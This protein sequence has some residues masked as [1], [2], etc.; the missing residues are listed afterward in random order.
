MGY[1]RAPLRAL[2]M[3]ERTA[4]ALLQRQAEAFGD[5]VFVDA[6]GAGPRTY[7]EVRDAVART[8][9]TL[10][11]A[12]VRTGDRVALLSSNRSELIDLVLGCAWMGAVAVPLN[13]ALRAGQLQHVLTN[14]APSVLVVEPQLVESLALV[15]RPDGLDHL[16]VLGQAAVGGPAGFEFEPMP[17]PGDFSEPAAVSPGQTMLILYTSGTTG[18]AKGVCCPQAQFYWWGVINSE[19]LGIDAST[20]LHTTLPLFHTNALNSLFQALVAGATYVSAPRFSASRY[21]QSVTER[22]ADVVYLLGAMIPM[23]LA[24]QPGEF[25]R[26]HRVRL[27]LAPA[28]PPA[29]YSAFADRFGVPLKD[30]YGS[31]ETNHVLGAPGDPTR[32]GYLGR[33]VAEFDVAVVDEHDQVVPDGAAGEMVVRNREPFSMAT[34]YHGLPERTL[35][36]FRNLWFHTGDRVTRD[37][38][39]WFRFVDRAKDAIRR[40]GENISS[41]EVEQVLTEHPDVQAVAAFPVPSELAE[42]EVMVAVVLKPGSRVDPLDLIRFCEPRLAY[43]AIPRFV[44]LVAELPLT[45]NGKVRKAVLRER[46]VGDATWDR[47]RVGY[48]L[49]R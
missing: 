1:L 2:P 39:G 43:F 7:A 21:W 6:A 33:A 42:D 23:L 49:R 3:P 45:E 18:L 48:V 25:D 37:E 17:A 4:P 34:C 8:A 46:G 11:A 12:G 5:R 40:R 31:T 44:D 15:R 29:L 13:T 22:G 32:P 24:Q 26:A 36:A 35:E 38:D 27:A 20:V 47:E 41:V 30:G 19:V 10:Q 9:G 16:W 28:T 14:A